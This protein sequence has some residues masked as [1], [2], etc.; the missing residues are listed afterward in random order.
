[1]KCM[2]VLCMISYPRVA[3]EAAR[4]RLAFRPK[5]GQMETSLV[6]DQVCMYMSV[7]VCVSL[8]ICVC[9]DEHTFALYIT[10][11]TTTTT[12]TCHPK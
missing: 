4:M 2:C 7:C 12:I 8:C 10:H 9:G 5:S 1:M 11:T 3:Y 6:F